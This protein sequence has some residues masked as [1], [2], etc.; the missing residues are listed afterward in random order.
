MTKHIFELIF[1][2]LQGNLIL[3]SDVWSHGID[4]MT[5]GRPLVVAHRGASGVRPA[6]SIEGYKVAIDS[7][8]IL[9]PKDYSGYFFKSQLDR[10]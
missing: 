3:A 8:K 7:G 1:I 10:S 2:V 4:G 6:H 9:P 5:D